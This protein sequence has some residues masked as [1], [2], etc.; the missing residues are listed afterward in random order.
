M[1]V[2]IRRSVP[3]GPVRAYRRPALYGGI[4]TRTGTLI[5]TMVMCQYPLKASVLFRSAVQ[6]F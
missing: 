2:G 5:G 4:K 1:L 6:G 3:P